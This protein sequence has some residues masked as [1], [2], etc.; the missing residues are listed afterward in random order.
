MRTISIIN[1]KFLRTDFFPVGEGDAS[2]AVDSLLTYNSQQYLAVNN[3]FWGE[4]PSNGLSF[5]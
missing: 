3:E 1:R 5:V 2:V 4:S